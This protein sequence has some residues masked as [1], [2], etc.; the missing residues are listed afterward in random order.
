MRKK[1]KKNISELRRMCLC[2]NAR[3]KNSRFR[4]SR[5][6]RDPSLSYSSFLRSIFLSGTK[7]N[8]CSIGILVIFRID[9]EIIREKSVYP[10]RLCQQ[11]SFFYVPIA[12]FFLYRGSIDLA[13]NR[14][15]R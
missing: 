13:Q 7:A 10:P 1:G 5:G 2:S 11:V 3:D 12:Y 6:R 14:A 9:I 15:A 4:N 8:I